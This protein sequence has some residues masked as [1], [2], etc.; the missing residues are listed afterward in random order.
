MTKIDN[1]I[2]KMDVTLYDKVIPISETISKC[3]VRIFYKGFNRNRTYITESFANELINSLP[4]TPIK[5]IFDNDEMDFEDHGEHNAEGRI[6]G[7][8]PENPNFQWEHH[9]DSDGIDRIYACADVFLYTE[10]YP[11]AKLIENKSQSMEIHRKGL[12]GEWKIWGEDGLPYFEFEHGHFL[13][14]QVLG[15]EVE[16]CFEGA[17]FFSFLKEASELLENINKEEEGGIETVEKN[18]FKLSDEAKWSI[19]YN[20]LNSSSEDKYYCIVAVYDDYALTFEHSDQSYYRVYYT[21][22]NEEETVSINS[23]QK[24]YIMDV[25]EEQKNYLE[26]V[27]NTNSYSIEDIENLIKNSLSEKEALTIELNELKEK[28]SEKLE[29]PIK[30]NFSAEN[31]Q[32]NKDLA[33]ANEKIAEYEGRLQEKESEIIRL[34]NLNTDITN[35]KSELEEFKKAIETEKKAAILNEF[36]SHLT[37]EQINNYNETMDNYSVADFKKEVC[38]T[39]YDSDPNIFSKK[40]SEELI[41]KNEDTKTNMTGALKLLSKHRKGGNK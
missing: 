17:A 40:D 28:M 8:V 12:Q 34:N 23:I 19:I 4:Y 32:L 1:D 35:E 38:V 21:K 20:T 37:E 7:V 27:T 14:L 9:L 24:V 25:T 11:E 5:G 10:L 30:E 29:E 39:A 26:S 6:Y 2:L 16:P 33:A 18:L 41:Y 36:S 3:R 13:G 15:D 22:N 31:E